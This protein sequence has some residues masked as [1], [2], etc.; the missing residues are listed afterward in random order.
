M[1]TEELLKPRYKVIADYPHSWFTIGEIIQDNF[2]SLSL[3][4]YP[5]I[6]KELKW[7]EKREVEDLPKY[8]KIGDCIRKV[9]KWD[10]ILDKVTVTNSKEDKTNYISLYEPS[11]EEEYLQFINQK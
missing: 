4:L 7:W 11:T 5:N 6:F 10:L 1:T 8:L 9:I 2:V 3:K